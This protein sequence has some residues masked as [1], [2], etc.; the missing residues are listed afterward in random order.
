ML[1]SLISLFPGTPRPSEVDFFLSLLHHFQSGCA[2]KW[3]S[4][5]CYEKR[6]L[7]FLIYNVEIHA[8]FCQNTDTWKAK[9]WYFCF[10]LGPRAYH[11]SPRILLTVLLSW[12]GCRW[13]TNARWRLLKI[14]NAFIGRRM[15]SFSLWWSEQEKAE[16]HQITYLG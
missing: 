6:G 1:L 14:I 10:S 9:S 15:W 5:T 2:L 13:C 16:K 3:A 8:I 12:F 7:H 11:H 4:F